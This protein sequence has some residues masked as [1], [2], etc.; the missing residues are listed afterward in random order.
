[1]RGSK[2]SGMR[3]RSSS[4]SSQSTVAGWTRAVTAA[5]VA[6]VTWRAASRPPVPPERTQAT[7]VSTVPK[8]SSPCLGPGPVRVDLIEDGH[9][10]GGRR[11]GGEPDALGL[12]RQAGPDR[13]QVLPADARRQRRAGG[14][15]PHNGRGALVGD[16]HA[17]DRTA[18]GQR[19]PGHGQHGAGHDAGVELD[20]PGRRRV[21]Q[22]G[23]VVHVL[24]GGV[25][26][27][28]GRPHPRRPD[29]D[30]EDAATGVAV[31]RRHVTTAA[32]RRARAD[33]TCPD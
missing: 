6:S 19:R 4:G 24:D 30:D 29:V 27:N 2:G 8:H 23:C 22:H 28:D 11:V 33:R 25:G 31:Q 7:Q 1:M 17:V 9:H 16:A 18:V 21:G 3:R 26:A 10:L 15:V 13:A 14:P 5:L 20:Q 12:E 32:D